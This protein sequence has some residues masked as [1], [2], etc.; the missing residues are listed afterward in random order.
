LLKDPAPEATGLK[1][2]KLEVAT[3]DDIWMSGLPLAS[4]GSVRF[5][6]AF[7]GCCPFHVYFFSYY[8]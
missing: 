6:S 3:D 8:I 7:F 2:M 1:P 4:A 5:L